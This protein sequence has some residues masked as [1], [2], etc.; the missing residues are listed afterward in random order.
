[1]SL[2]HQ[3]GYVEIIDNICGFVYFVSEVLSG[4]LTM[5]KN[6]QILSIVSKLSWMRFNFSDLAFFILNDIVISVSS[7]GAPSSLDSA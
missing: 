7:A 5:Q 2:C 3:Q 6:F 1:M 4:S